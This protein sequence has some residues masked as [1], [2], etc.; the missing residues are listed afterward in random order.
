MNK[1]ILRGQGINPKKF[2]REIFTQFQ[3]WLG[4]TKGVEGCP[5][6]CQYCFFKLDNLT[7]TQPKEINPPEIILEQLKLAPTYQEN[8][9]VHFGS[10]TDAFSTKTNIEYYSKLIALYGESNYKNPLIFNS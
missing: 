1:E 2:N 4:E 7:P 8:I 9:P 10:Q 5:I 3:T 6:N